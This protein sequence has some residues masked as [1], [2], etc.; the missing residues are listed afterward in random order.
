MTLISSS[1]FAVCKT[2]ESLSLSPLSCSTSTRISQSESFY[3]SKTIFQCR[4]IR[5]TRHKLNNSAPL[6]LE[7]AIKIITKLSAPGQLVG[8]CKTKKR[9]FISFL[10]GVFVCACLVCLVL[11]SMTESSVATSAFHSMMVR[12]GKCSWTGRVF[13]RIF[14]VFV[15]ILGKWYSNYL[16]ITR[17]CYCCHSSNRN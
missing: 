2:T 14:D 8:R 11:L 17:C 7:T 12:L 9:G 16:L 4:A 10:V 6:T 15:L 3:F 1:A 5:R 13:G